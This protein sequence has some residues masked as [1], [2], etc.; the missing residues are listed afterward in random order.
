MYYEPVNNWPGQPAYFV[1]GI[2]QLA[3]NGHVIDSLRQDTVLPIGPNDIAGVA[4]VNKIW[5]IKN[6]LD[7]QLRQRFFARCQ[8]QQ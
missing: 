1:G 5:E 3:V 4:V 7:G 6:E 8:G 2:G